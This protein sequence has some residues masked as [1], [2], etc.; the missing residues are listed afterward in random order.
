MA[1][2]AGQTGLGRCWVDLVNLQEIEDLFRYRWDTV[3]VICLKHG[4]MRYGELGSAITTWAGT[5]LADGVL[6]RS[7]RR[8]TEAELVRL[9]D[10]GDGHNAYTLTVQGR[11]RLAKIAAIGRAVRQPGEQR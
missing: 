7:L 8:L 6:T 1:E 2:A 3:V 9:T 5:R 11:A 10:D 4:P